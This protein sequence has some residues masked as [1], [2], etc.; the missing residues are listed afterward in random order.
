MKIVITSKN[1]PVVKAAAFLKEKKGR[2][3]T[4]TFLVEGEKM[5]AECIAAGLEIERVFLSERCSEDFE[6]RLLEDLASRGGTAEKVVWLS[7]SAFCALSDEKTPQ[8]VACVVKI[9]KNDPIPP[10]GDCLLLD[11]IADPGNLGTIIRTANAAGYKQ[12]YLV[13]CA[14]EYSPKCVR[15][16]M[17]GIF[18]VETY[19]VSRE[20]ALRLLQGVPIFAADMC[21][22]N[23]FFCAVPEKIALAIGNEAN[24]LSSEVRSAASRVVSVPMQ[25][26]QESLNAA[27]AA[28]LTMY[29]LRKEKFSR[30]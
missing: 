3:R 24:G 1:N 16:S 11:G 4:G 23:V 6:K 8:G 5:T 14:D 12:L 15:A 10:R 28:A 13:S 26:K 9:P 7:E 2:A 25:G 17:S 19:D 27:V 18:F 30:T 20:E 29:L 22:E 21:G